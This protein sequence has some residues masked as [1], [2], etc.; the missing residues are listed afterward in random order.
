MRHNENSTALPLTTGQS[1]EDVLDVPCFLVACANR[2]SLLDLGRQSESG[3]L[4]NDVIAD[5]IVIGG[6]HRMWPLCDLHN[7]P[8][9]A[10]RGEDGVGGCRR[11]RTRRARDT[12]NRYR[13]KEENAK[14]RGE[15]FQQDSTQMQRGA[16]RNRSLSGAPVTVGSG[17]PTTTGSV[18]PV[19][20]RLPSSQISA[21]PQ[22]M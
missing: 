7:V 9:R 10:F 6:A 2:R 5:A 1:R 3:D 19:S 16:R 22:H 17:Q 21:E 20:D 13:A 18:E 11:N 4:A 8:H 14:R 15:P 12:E